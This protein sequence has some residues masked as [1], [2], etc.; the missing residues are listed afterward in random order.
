MCGE[1]TMLDFL[2][3]KKVEYEF[4]KIRR[5]MK[6]NVL[7]QLKNVKFNEYEINEV[8]QIIDNFYKDFDKLRAIIND[9]YAENKGSLTLE[10]YT[11]IYMQKLQIEVA[12]KIKM[13]IADIIERKT[14]F[15]K[16]KN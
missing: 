11:H 8:T 16:M 6:K 12:E 5:N 3:G 10:A 14:Y 13:K 15:D 4:E 2:F 9:S 7:K 1:K